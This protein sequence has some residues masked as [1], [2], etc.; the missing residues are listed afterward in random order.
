MIQPNLNVLFWIWFVWMILL[1]VCCSS[2]TEIHQRHK[3]IVSHPDY[4]H[5]NSIDDQIEDG[6]L[7]PNA[8]ASRDVPKTTP[9]GDYIV[10]G[11]IVIP[12]E[13]IENQSNGSEGL[14]GRTAVAEPVLYWPGGVVV[15]MYHQC[16]CYDEI[17]CET[18]RLQYLINQ[19]YQ[20]PKK[21][22][23]NQR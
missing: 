1:K 18:D 8:L 11:D 13:V 9:D 3:R 12:R 5:S 15:Y 23:S 6:I 10:E 16:E 17:I 14:T 20:R 19:L 21:Q 7:P 4:K 2:P 22:S